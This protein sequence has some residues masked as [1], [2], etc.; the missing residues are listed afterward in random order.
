MA[1]KLEI[2][3]DV[4]V[5]V[6]EHDGPDLT[7]QIQIVCEPFASGTYNGDPVPNYAEQ[8]E[9]QPTINGTTTYHSQI[10]VSN[11]E[12]TTPVF[13]FKPSKW[14]LEN[15]K[16][17][18][19]VPEEMN[20]VIRFIENFYYFYEHVEGGDEI[21][22][23]DTDPEISNATKKSS[24]R[25]LKSV[26]EDD[27]NNNIIET[28]NEFLFELKSGEINE[29][30]TKITYNFTSN[31]NL[32]RIMKVLQVPYNRHFLLLVFLKML[33]YRTHILLL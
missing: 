28:N 14:E 7:E 27:D 2:N 1:L 23:E 21:K 12:F 10:Q 8:T 9:L 18:L 29:E 26:Q 16:L 20:D 5:R 32:T 24:A 30:G 31:R 15:G 6:I 25:A 33:L 22:R 3:F 17:K 4:K 19:T 13:V 11:T